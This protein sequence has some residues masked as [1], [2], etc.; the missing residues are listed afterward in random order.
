[1]KICLWETFLRHWTAQ[2]ILEKFFSRVRLSKKFE[3]CLYIQLIDGICLV[4]Y[5][6]NL[7]PSL[8]ST[9]ES[10]LDHPYRED[11]NRNS[12]GKKK[13]SKE[14]IVQIRLDSKN[15]SEG[16]W[17]TLLVCLHNGITETVTQAI[18]KWNTQK[19]KITSK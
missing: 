2:K 18:I 1:M 8:L 11:W 12:I 16:L 10:L 14:I 17:A 13:P 15:Y 3:Q 5:T 6:C 19:G 7:R 4:S 9:V